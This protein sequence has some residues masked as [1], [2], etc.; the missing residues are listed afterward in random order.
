MIRAVDTEASSLSQPCIM[1][2]AKIFELYGDDAHSRGH[3][4]EVPTTG[5]RTIDD[6]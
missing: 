3:C 1:E 4:R 2:G 5:P 6:R